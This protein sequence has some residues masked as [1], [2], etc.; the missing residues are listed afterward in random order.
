MFADG[1]ACFLNNRLSASLSGFFFFAGQ[2]YL[3]SV[4]VHGDRQSVAEKKA[5]TYDGI[6]GTTAWRCLFV[7]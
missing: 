7:R 4:G 2:K 6:A 1:D 5:G 3:G